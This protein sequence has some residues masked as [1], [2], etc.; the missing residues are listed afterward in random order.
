MGATGALALAGCAVGDDDGDDTADGTD[1][2][3]GDDGTTDDGTGDTTTGDTDTTVR[4][5][6]LQDFSGVLPQYG[7]QGTTG[8]YGGLAYKADDDPLPMDAVDAGE[9]DYSVGDIDVELL[10]RDTQW[11]PANTNE[12]AE[13]LVTDDNVDVLYGVGNSAGALRVITQTVERTDVP[14]IAGPAA[15]A[16]ITADEETCRNQVFRANENTAMDA[17]SGGVYIAEQTDVERM[18]L[19]GVDNPFGQSVVDNYRTVFENRGVEI[20]EDRAV[21]EGFD[22]WGGILEDIEGEVDGMVAG[23]TAATLIPFGTQFLQGGYDIQLFGGFASRVT[24]GPVGGILAQQLG[25]NFTNEGITDAQFGPFTTRYHWNQYDNEIN[26]Q[27]VEDHIDAYDIVPDLFTGGAFTAASS[28]IQ[29]VQQSGEASRDAII[30]EMRGMTVT[31]TPKGENGYEYQ[32]YNNQ[33]RSQMTVANVEVT[34]DDQEAWE[35]VIQPGD[36]I[37]TVPADEVTIPADEMSCDLS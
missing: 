18:A 24:L 36:P 26:Q 31:D 27:F 21:P 2:T 15:S 32:L 23:F 7:E 20:V 19:F 34:P 37:E 17:R 12:L 30:S 22:E 3:T 13:D 35:P 4:I 28:I 33:A 25:E 16:E 6:V 29:A 9:Y 11:D 10:V 1:D 14:F 8:F 5:G